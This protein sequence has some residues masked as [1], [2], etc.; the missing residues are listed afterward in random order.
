M[1]AKFYSIIV[2]PDDH[3]HTHQYRVSRNLMVGLAA[4]AVVFMLT[5]I[6]FGATYGRVLH[7]ARRLA[8]VESENEVLRGNMVHLNQLNDEL[9]QLSSL[10]AQVVAMLGSAGVDEDRLEV[11]EIVDPG[12]ALSDLEAAEFGQL[13]SAESIWRA[14]PTGWP[15]DAEVSVEFFLAESEGQEAHPGLDLRPRGAATAVVAAGGGRVLGVGESE[16]GG[17]Y[18]LVDHGLGVVSRYARLERISVQA[19]QMVERGQRLAYL[20]GSD[21]GESS[22]LYFEIRVDGEPVNPR[23]YLEK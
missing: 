4:I 17:E 2:V 18:V 12:L 6:V 14:L 13:R 15:A 20:N 3:G 23:H 8:V 21:R 11:D 9:E 16:A 10:R 19:G 7:D 22:D 5:I 1:A